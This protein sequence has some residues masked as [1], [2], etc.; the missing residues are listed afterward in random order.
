MH[1]QCPAGSACVRQSEWFHQC[2]PGAQP[3]PAGGPATGSPTSPAGP[4]AAGV[5]LWDQCGGRGGSCA[6][7]GTCTD[8]PLPGVSCP[9]ACVRHSEWFWQCMPAPS[10][11]GAGSPSSSD[12]SSPGGSKGAAGGGAGSIGVWQQCGGL[13]GGCLA[14]GGCADGPFPGG[15]RQLHV[16]QAAPVGH[17]LLGAV[18]CILV[19]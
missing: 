7:H 4:A 12:G 5:A 16:L 15:W 1:P 3:P 17:G 6:S 19:G 18:L 10:S 13:G 11:G 14:A 8:A 9:G 2:V